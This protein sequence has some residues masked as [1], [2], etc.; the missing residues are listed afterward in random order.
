VCIGRF[1]DA[2]AVGLYLVKSC[3]QVSV[4]DSRRGRL[5]VR[6]GRI[7]DFRCAPDGDINLFSR[8]GEADD[9]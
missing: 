8:F 7:A 6:A 5:R 3:K 9:N 4:P 2:N 1:R